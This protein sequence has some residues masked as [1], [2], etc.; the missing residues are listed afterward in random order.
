VDEVYRFE[1]IDQA[2][3]SICRR[4]NVE[5]VSPRV[6]TRGGRMSADYRDYYTEETRRLV[7]EHFREEI[8]RFRYSFG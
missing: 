7:A 5:F 1:S 2:V 3:A 8:E 6:D 4:L